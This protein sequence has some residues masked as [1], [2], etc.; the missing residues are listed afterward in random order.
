MD[1]ETTLIIVIALG[2][3][4]VAIIF[5][6]YRSRAHRAAWEELAAQLGLQFT[7]GN[8][9]GK[10]ATVSGIYHGH[11]MQMNTFSRQMGRNRV[12]Y[13]RI[14]F[15]VENTAELWLTISNE[16]LGSKLKKMVGQKEISLGD[17]ALDAEYFIQG[18][19]E[20]TV[21]RILSSTNL[22]Q[23][24]L[25][26]KSVHIELKSKEI[27]SEKRG[28]EANPEKLQ[29][30]FDLLGGMADAVNRFGADAAFVVPQ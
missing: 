20:I 19:P 6:I 14:A 25:D 7:A 23:K 28:F 11:A 26:A 29:A 4:A 5:T 16:S 30:M 2:L 12:T 13:T 18:S 17:E 15:E 9:W 10:S 1:N 22:R 3:M 24:L 27:Y 21:Q 8:F